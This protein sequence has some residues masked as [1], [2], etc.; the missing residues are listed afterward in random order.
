MA[1]R[2]SSSAPLLLSA[3][4]T[5]NAGSLLLQ[6]AVP[7]WLQYDWSGAGDADPSARMHFGLFRGHDRVVFWGE[8]ME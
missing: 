2:D 4:G 5:G 3:P 7:A 1:G 6:L 8:R